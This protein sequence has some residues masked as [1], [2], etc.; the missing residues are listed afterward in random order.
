MF[1]NY[2][3]WSFAPTE[4]EMCNIKLKYDNNLEVP[5]NFIKTAEAYQPDNPKGK[6]VTQPHSQINPQTTDFCNK[7][8]IDDPLFLVCKSQNINNSM[9]EKEICNEVTSDIN[10][11]AER[12]T[13]MKLKLSLPEPVNSS[14]EDSILTFDTDDSVAVENSFII[15]TAGSDTSELQS[16]RPK[17]FVRRNADIYVDQ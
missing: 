14:C 8:G 9:I 7:L 10:Q 16:P 12:R 3:R 11:G 6:G 13:S 4:E 15:D 5:D 1:I 17:K 2:C